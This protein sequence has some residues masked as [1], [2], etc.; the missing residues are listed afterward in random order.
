MGFNNRSILGFAILGLLFCLQFLV[1][2]VQQT[3]DGRARFF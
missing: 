3:G 1:Q 2:G